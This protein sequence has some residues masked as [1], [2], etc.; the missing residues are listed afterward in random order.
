MVTQTLKE[1]VR[2]SM[3]DGLAKTPQKYARVQRLILVIFLAPLTLHANP[4]SEDHG[5]TPLM[6]AAYDGNLE[7]VKRLIEKGTDVN[8]RD[9][10]GVSALWMSAGATPMF[11]AT[12]ADRASLDRHIN[13][14][15]RQTEV[16]RY[17]IAHGADV[18]TRTNNGG[19]ALLAAVSNSNVESV[20]AL[21]EHGANV[22]AARNDGDTPLLR[23]TAYGSAPIARLLLKYGAIVNGIYD[24]NGYT[25]LM[26]AIAHR[27]LLIA[28]LLIA[29]GANV[30]DSHASG[31]TPLLL[32]VKSNQP[33]LVKT[34]VENGADVAT[35]DGDG[36]TALQL[37]T[38]N[39]QI[40]IAKLLRSNP[41]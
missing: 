34:L 37:A 16:L 1:L 24:I 31:E 17:L 14:L 36:R 32:A 11:D 8:Q 25:P 4:P 9:R 38:A 2:G 3:K 27:N 10:L 41:H 6:Q 28:E 26:T 29:H 22:N 21:L 30:N 5:D 20:E 18:N 12:R 40:E 13:H 19:T 23:A 35:F 7:T 15:I 39:R 33:D